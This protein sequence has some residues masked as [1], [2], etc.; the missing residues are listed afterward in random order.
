[1][2]LFKALFNLVNMESLIPTREHDI[3]TEEIRRTEDDR[4]YT[5]VEAET[6][7]QAFDKARELFSNYRATDPSC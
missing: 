2:S 3:P 7:L 4:Y 1:M 5:Y 6:P